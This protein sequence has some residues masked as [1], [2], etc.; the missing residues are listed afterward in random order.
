MNA[1]PP[2]LTDRI[3][4]RSLLIRLALASLL[5][6]LIGTPDGVVRAQNPPPEPPVVAPDPVAPVAP[7]ERDPAGPD[8]PDA[9]AVPE[10]QDPP[11][12]AQLAKKKG[13]RRGDPEVVRIGQ[14]VEVAAGESRQSVVVIN[15]YATID[16]RVEEDLVVVG[17]SARINGSVGGNVV[18]VGGGIILGPEARI[19]GDAVGVLGGIRMGNDSR[20]DGSAYGIVG[21]VHLSPG[22]K[23]RG[24]TIDQ[25]IPLPFSNWVGADGFQPPSWVQATFAELLLKFRPLSFSVGW[26]WIVAGLFWAFY[27]LLA[28]AAPGTIRSVNDTLSQR[29]ATSFLMGFL[30]LPLGALI[31][32][33][34]L[35]TGVGVIVIPFVGAAFL[36]AALIGKAGLLNFFGATAA[37]RAEKEISPALSITIGAVLLAALYLIPFL[38]IVSWAV[39][40]MW[41]LGAAILAL[42]SR[43]RSEKIP[44]RMS[45]PALT[46]LALTGTDPRDRT[47]AQTLMA[48]A[49]GESITGTDASD[50]IRPEATAAIPPIT[51]ATPTSTPKSEDSGS[52]P[53]RPMPRPPALWPEVDVLTLPRVGLKERLLASLLDWLLL[54]MLLGSI[55]GGGNR[56]KVV[57]A[58]AYFAGFWIWR[59]TTLGGII[60]RLKV[61][62][63]DGRPVD[64]A[65]AI[66]RALGSVFAI[67]ALGLGYFWSAWDSEK[68]GWHDKIAGTVVV[69]VPK[70]QPLV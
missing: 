4:A 30:A 49:T 32:L 41:A 17:G 15:S 36:F 7:V 53:P 57:A 35:V 44:Q 61:A 48:V 47:D 43:F 12:L 1:S 28:L 8:E 52:A 24:E 70:T 68:Q 51:Q 63:L 37:R 16:G 11:F 55:H 2:P 45:T 6:F 67:L 33:F 34:L 69:K 23:I 66:V 29:G 59:Q 58:L 19:G 38:G 21:G 54:A 65:T 60:L 14:P 42:L 40:S 3:P 10:P 26:V 56:W 46:T 64:P 9:P 25:S 50:V 18:N 39:F 31:T 20:I 27:V 62:R 5:I 22:A 13:H